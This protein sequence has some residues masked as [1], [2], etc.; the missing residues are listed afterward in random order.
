MTSE[1]SKPDSNYLYIETTG[2]ILS[3]YCTMTRGKPHL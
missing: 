2:G 1:K 3:Q